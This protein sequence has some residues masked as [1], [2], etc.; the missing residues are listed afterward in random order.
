MAK[1]PV[2]V[3]K[4]GGTINCYKGDTGWL[5]RVCCDHLS[6]YCNDLA[7]AKVQ[8][9]RLEKF[10]RQSLKI[11]V[12]AIRKEGLAFRKL[13]EASAAPYIEEQ[14]YLKPINND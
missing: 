8:L 3:S 11:T 10:K 5:F 7:S 9:D 6:L 1:K 2:Y 4:Q 13:I 12:N 14:S